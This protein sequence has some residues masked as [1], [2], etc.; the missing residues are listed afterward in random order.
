M[1]VLEFIPYGREN[2]IKRQDLRDMLGVSDRDM[3]ELIAQARKETPIIN[4]SDGQGYYRPNEKEDLMRYILQEQARSIKIMKN[5]RV[6]IK[7]YNKI[8]GQLTLE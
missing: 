1:N 5:I 8:V 6:A 7:E 3:R 2:A 4:L